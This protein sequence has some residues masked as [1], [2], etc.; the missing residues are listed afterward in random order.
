MADHDTHDHTGIPGVG[1]GGISSGTSNPGSPS[2][3]DLFYRTDLDLLIRYRSSGT[4]WVTTTL[5]R[6]TFG[7]GEVSMPR[8]SGAGT[9]SLGKITPWSTAFDLY[10]E[11]FYTSTYVLTTN[12]GTNY[13]GLALAKSDAA[14]SDTTIVSLNTS[15]HTVNNWTQ[16]QTAIGAVYVAASY[17]LLHV[18]ATPTLSPGNLF[19]ALAVSYRLIVT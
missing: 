9:G 18:I 15:A 5:Y 10:L 2:D 6:E 3:G 1:G 16:V 8:T 19:W 14:A 4:R 7:L 12:N 11:N 13:W 17:R